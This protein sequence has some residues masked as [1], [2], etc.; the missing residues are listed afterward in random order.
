MPPRL[1]VLL[2]L[3][4]IRNRGA[5]ANGFGLGGLVVVCELVRR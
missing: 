3:R 5:D 2:M 4:Q 1:A